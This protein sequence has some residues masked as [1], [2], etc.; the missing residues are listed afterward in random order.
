MRRELRAHNFPPENRARNISRYIREKRLRECASWKGKGEGKRVY[1][2]KI[3]HSC[4]ARRWKETESTKQMKDDEGLVLYLLWHDHRPLRIV[5]VDDCECHRLW[6][7]GDWEGHVSRK[8]S[9]GERNE[10]RRGAMMVGGKNDELLGV[11]ATGKLINAQE[12]YVGL[13][14]ITPREIVIPL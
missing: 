6:D 2:Q 12:N 9:P 8:R 3:L 5:N 11:G 1:R 10:G 7:I 4:S 13:A 14:E